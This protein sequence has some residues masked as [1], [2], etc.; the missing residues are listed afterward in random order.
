VVEGVL[1]TLA[2]VNLGVAVFNLI[3]GLP[4]DGGRVLRAGLW[5]LTGSYTRATRVAAAGGELLAALLIALGLFLALAGHEPAGL[6]YVPMGCSS[7]SWPGRPAEG[8]DRRS[9]QVR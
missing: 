9:T 4:L 6:W 8:A 1:G 5:R 7:G 3:P 2:L